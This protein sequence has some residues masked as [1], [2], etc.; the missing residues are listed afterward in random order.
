MKLAAT[1]TSDLFG[2]GRQIEREQRGR[3]QPGRK[4]ADHAYLLGLSTKTEDDGRG[5]E[6]RAGGLAF[7]QCEF[8]EAVV[9]DDGADGFAAGYFEG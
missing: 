4:G 2:V 1:A 5:F 9:R 8:F 6:Y 7:R 3:E